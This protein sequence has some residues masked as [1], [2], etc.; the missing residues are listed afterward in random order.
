MVCL[1]LTFAMIPK[2]DGDAPPPL[3]PIGQRPLRVLPVVYR[4]WASVR[5]RHLEDR[6]RSWLPSSVF[7]AGAE[8]SSVE[9]WFSTAL[10]IEEV[11]SEFS[12][13]DVLVLVADVVKTFDTVDGR[14]RV[15][16][17]GP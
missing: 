16:G 8:R 7:S 12:D 6:L 17:G 4:L 15:E 2:A 11:L 1:T 14:E 3:S 9:A 5:L 13:T 10:D